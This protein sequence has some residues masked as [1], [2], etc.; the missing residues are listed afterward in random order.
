MPKFKFLLLKITAA[1]V[2]FNLANADLGLEGL[3]LGFAWAMCE[4]AQE[5]TARRTFYGGTITGFICY[6]T[7]LAFFWN[8][9]GGA[10]II[11]WLILAVFLGGFALC[12]RQVRTQWGVWAAIILA[13]ALWVGW[14]YFRSELYYL[15]FA[16][17]SL[18]STF[19]DRECISW[20][21]AA[22][23]YGASA[24]I[25]LAGVGLAEVR[26]RVKWIAL[27][28]GLAGF[29]LLAGV[30]E[31]NPEPVSDERVDAGKALPD[32]QALR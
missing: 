4:I 7:Q 14:E 13:P 6:A 5:Q 15:R 11:L 24:L 19:A 10:A 23:C 8:I 9:F 28:I 31:P 20:A 30:G 17:F 2:L 16:W 25:M 22:G 12:L 32:K 29:V 26:G 1:A 3:I 18:G 27:G 21:M